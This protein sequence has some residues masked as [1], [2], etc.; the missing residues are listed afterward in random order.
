MPAHSRWLTT[1]LVSTVLAVPASS[2]AQPTGQTPAEFQKRG[3]DRVQHHQF[4]E[5]IIDFTEA[6]RLNPKDAASYV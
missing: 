1:W 4:E 6:I 5:A 2:P 3:L